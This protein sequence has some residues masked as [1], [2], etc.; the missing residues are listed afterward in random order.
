MTQRLIQHLERQTSLAMGG[1]DGHALATVPRAERT[2][3]ASS[4]AKISPMKKS[5]CKGQE[6]VQTSKTSKRKLKL[7]DQ[8]MSFHGDRA[9]L[10]LI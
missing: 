2:S 7:R 10:I 6:H 1:C 3:S 5:T 9:R 8:A 4:A